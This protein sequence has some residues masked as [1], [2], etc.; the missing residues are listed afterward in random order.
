[1]EVL[2]KK[3]LLLAGGMALLAAAFFAGRFSGRGQFFTAGGQ[4][5]LDGNPQGAFV[6]EGGP[7]SGESFAGEVT[8]L[9]G[10]QP[11]R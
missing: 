1:L 5:A 9:G 2:M 3:A 6:I 11:Q 10:G 7:Q 8:A 4:R